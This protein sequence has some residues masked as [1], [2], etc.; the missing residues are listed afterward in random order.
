MVDAILREMRDDWEKDHP[1]WV[2]D[3]FVHGTRS[4]PVEHMSIADYTISATRKEDGAKIVGSGDN[5]AE[6]IAA[7]TVQ[8]GRNS[9]Q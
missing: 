1:G 8:V 6:A 2:T 4:L 9:L 3:D 5:P 7:L